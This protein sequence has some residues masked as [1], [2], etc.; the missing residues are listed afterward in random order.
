MIC[1]QVKDGTIEISMGGPA[2]GRDG[3][4]GQSGDRRPP[5]GSHADAET[6]ADVVGELATSQP[7]VE[8]TGARA[9]VRPGP[10]WDNFVDAV[11]D[12]VYGKDRAGV[13]CS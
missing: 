10:L 7:Q 2:T 11:A 12:D 13:G 9:A 8:L 6:F 4:A 3:W 1:G 5:G